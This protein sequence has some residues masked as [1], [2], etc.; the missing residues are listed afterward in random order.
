MTNVILSTPPRTKGEKI[1]NTIYGYA[2]ISTMK[3]SIQ[4]QIANIK[5]TYPNAIIV[6]EEYTGTKIDRPAFS[7]L[8]KTVKAGDTIVFDEVSRMS[9]NAE[10][11]FKLYEELY[12]KGVELVFL[13]ESTLNTEN[14]RQTQQIATVGNDIADI[15][16]KATNEVLMI[17]AKKQIIKA[18]ETAQHEVDFLHQRTREGLAQ[19][20]LNGKQIGNVKGQKYNTKKS[21]EMKAKIKALSK[22]FD[23]TNND[24]EVMAIT[25]LA[26]NTY[27]KYKRE[28][29][30]EVTK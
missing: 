19:A 8:L 21:Q 1:M 2:R 23:G 25:K 14:F 20:K 26:R 30:E 13:K 10:D 28:M 11:G 15:Y 29:L 3:Q 18:F 12:N 24:I 9:R 6:T 7:K 16:I 5:A 4:R 22:D 27:Y 17:L